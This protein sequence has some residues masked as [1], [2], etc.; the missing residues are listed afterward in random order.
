MGISQ[1]Y[2]PGAPEFSMNRLFGMFHVKTLQRSKDNIV[3]SLQDPNRVVRVVFASVAIGM[4]VNLQ[5]VNII[6]HYGAPNSIED[7]FQ[8]RIFITNKDPVI[9][10]FKIGQFL[11]PTFY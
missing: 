11:F 6:L 5:R 1:Y 2:P 7:F 10:G 9:F 3:R 4:G 8:L